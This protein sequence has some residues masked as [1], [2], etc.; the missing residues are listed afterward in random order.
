VLFPVGTAVDAQRSADLARALGDRFECRT[1]AQD[2]LAPSDVDDAHLIVLWSWQQMADMPHRAELLTRSRA[3]LVAGWTTPDGPWDPDSEEGLVA[4]ATLRRVPRTVVTFSA[5]AEALLRPHLTGTEGAGHSC[6]P[7]GVD[8][9]FF[10]PGPRVAAPGALRVGWAGP[11]HGFE[12]QLLGADMLR[13]AVDA[14]ADVEWVALRPDV[15]H[16]PVQ[17]RAFYHGLD[18][19]LWAGAGGELP[20]WHLEAAACG[21]LPLTT[22]VGFAREVTGYGVRGMILE[23]TTRA[24]ASALSALRDAPQRRAEMSVALRG[25][26]ATQGSWEVRAEGFAHLFQNLLSADPTPFADHWR[27]AAFAAE[28][29]AEHERALPL[30]QRALT[31]APLHTETLEGMARTYAALGHAHTAASL[32][33]RAHALSGPAAQRRSAKRRTQRNSIAK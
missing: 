30:W 21:V 3:K 16:S 28:A 15:V 24:F 11:S 1:V 32:R 26:M 29:A 31:A 8:T 25:W 4:L 12:G 27:T 33:Q 14:T 13:S 2:R 18:A 10:A 5:A 19:V 20:L 7:P 17:R 22:D 9:A 23:P 6:V